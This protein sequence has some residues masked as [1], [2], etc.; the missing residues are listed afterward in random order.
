MPNR[1][2]SGSRGIIIN[3]GELIRNACSQASPHTFRIRNLAV[4]PEICFNKPSPQWFCACSI[5]EPPSEA[6][7]AR[8]CLS[9]SCFA[10]TCCKLFQS[11]GNQGELSCTFSTMACPCN[12]HT[13]CVNSWHSNF[14]QRLH[15]S[16]HKR[17]IHWCLKI[18]NCF[19][20]ERNEKKKVTYS[21]GNSSLVQPSEN[22]WVGWS[23]VSLSSWTYS[24]SILNNRGVYR[25]E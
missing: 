13:N 4:G 17:L 3:T 21:T 9:S 12:K 19:S 5:W 20:Y 23:K 7:S 11:T 2:V 6:K 22:Q 25:G 14:F 8:W 24:S 1:L 18:T 16:E 10:L 15:H